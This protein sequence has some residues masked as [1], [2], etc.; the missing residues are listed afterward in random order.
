MSFESSPSA[1]LEH[2]EDVLFVSIRR[3]HRLLQ[4]STTIVPGEPQIGVSEM[5]AWHLMVS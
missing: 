5:L 4:D 2:I 3:S 1:A